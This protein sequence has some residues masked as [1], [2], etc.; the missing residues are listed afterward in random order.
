MSN[1]VTLFGAG[2]SDVPAHIAE[3][4]EEESNIQPRVS[5]PSLGYEGKIWT[6][7]VGGEKTQ[8]TKKDEEGDVVPLPIFRVVILATAKNRGRAYYEGNYDPEN[9]GRPACWSDDGVTPDEHVAEPQCGTC[10]ECPLSA[11]GSRISDNGK[12]TVACSQHRMV[13]VVPAKKLDF[14]PLRMKIAV[15]SDWDKQSPEHAE[16]NWFA[17]TQYTDFLFAKGV[18]HTAGVVTKM[19]FDPNA[20][21]PKI[22]FS[23]DRWV[24]VDEKATITPLISS[25]EVTSLIEGTWTVTGLDGTEVDGD[26]EM[27]AAE[28]EA[29]AAATKK[30]EAAAAKKAKADAAAAKKAEA[31][32][33]KKAKADAAAAKKA[34]A[35]APK[36]AAQ[37]VAQELM[38]D[39]DDGGLDAKQ[40]QKSTKNATTAEPTDAGGD[41]PDD[42][43]A[44][45]NEWDEE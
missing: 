39:D 2:S 1:Q 3:L 32:A 25:P 43:Q 36:T 9:P 16:N 7:S 45:L 8:L 31:A 44:L 35:A 20:A 6:I 21:Y 30:A 12:E 5:V 24:E 27:L 17:L 26:D 13:V 19:R 14:Q 34:E 33:A 18:K 4:F 15:T 23:P 38:D 37:T 40:L 41:I 28:A 22:L 42:V 10:S 29:D 11:K